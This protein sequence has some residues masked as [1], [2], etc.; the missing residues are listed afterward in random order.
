MPV[1]LCILKKIYMNVKK[2][3]LFREGKGGGGE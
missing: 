2:G 1:E 3:L